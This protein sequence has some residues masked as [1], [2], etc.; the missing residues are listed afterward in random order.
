M[1]DGD[2]FVR[3]KH[4]IDNTIHRWVVGDAYV[5]TKTRVKNLMNRFNATPGNIKNMVCVNTY[6]I[7][8][9]VFRSMIR[10]EIRSTIK[11]LNDEL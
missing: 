1:L 2:C 6:D 4:M 5:P 3:M 10:C 11:F 9:S 7:M 8:N